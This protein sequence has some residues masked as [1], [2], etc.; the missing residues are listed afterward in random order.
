MPSPDLIGRFPD[1]SI[2]ELHC[3]TY[4]NTTPVPCVCTICS[5]SCRIAR[6]L[7]S[8]PTLDI[9][10]RWLADGLCVFTGTCRF[11]DFYA[12][13][14]PLQFVHCSFP[15]VCRSFAVRCLSFAVR[16]RFV[17]RSSPLRLKFFT[18]RCRFVIQTNSKQS[19]T[20]GIWNDRWLD[21]PGP[22]EAAR[23][24]RNQIYLTQVYRVAL[25]VS[26]KRIIKFRTTAVK[27]AIIK[28]PFVY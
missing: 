26:L 20:S 27:E 14:S 6:K 19:G 21:K 18:V 7:L 17:C 12:D 11:I 24:H 3:Q 25:G 22:Y 2:W 4:T 8:I 5:P 1:I 28:I 23:D 16:C 10:L 9:A 15:C 13:K